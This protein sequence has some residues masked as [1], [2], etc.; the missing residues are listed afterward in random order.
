MLPFFV[1]TTTR[2]VVFFKYTRVEKIVL[3][4]NNIILPIITSPIQN[5]FSTLFEAHTHLAQYSQ[6]I[7][8]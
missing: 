7:Y 4:P 6:Y 1:G 3:Q 5:I 2:N 8:P